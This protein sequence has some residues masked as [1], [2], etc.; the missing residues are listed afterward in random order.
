MIALYLVYIAVIV[1]LITALW[2][3]FTK[4]GY[5]GWGAIIPIYNTYLMIKIAG[6]P[7]WWLVLMFV[8]IVNIVIEIMV[9]LGIARNFGKSTGFGIG[10]ILLS[11]IFYP[12]LA[13]GSA[14]Y[15]PETA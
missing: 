15:Q 12:I 3:V 7:G 11:F 2:V 13:F 8:P 14:T 10:L 4:A 5:P 6:K 1:F 9:A